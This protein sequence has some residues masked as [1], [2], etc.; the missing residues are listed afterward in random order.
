VPA[1]ATAASIYIGY[2]QSAPWLKGLLDE[3]AY[4]PTA[5]DATRIGLH[6]HAGCGC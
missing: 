4:F 2:G 3:A 1:I 5:L 6:Y